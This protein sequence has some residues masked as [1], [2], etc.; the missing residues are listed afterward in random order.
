MRTGVRR[1]MAHGSK[2]SHSPGPNSQGEHDQPME[3]RA[4]PRDISVRHP[5]IHR[6]NERHG[7]G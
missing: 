5:N 6:T 3:W 7:G 2:E 1:R 4:S